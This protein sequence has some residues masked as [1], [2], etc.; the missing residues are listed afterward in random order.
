MERER[1]R[2]GESERLRERERCGVGG[3]DRKVGE[4]VGWEGGRGGGEREVKTREDARKGSTQKRKDEG[5]QSSKRDRGA[6]RG[7]SKLT[8]T[9]T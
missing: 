2:V 8:H 3:T 6:G 5:S 7:E 9:H 1:G 4:G